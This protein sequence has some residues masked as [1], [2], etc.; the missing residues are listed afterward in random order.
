MNIL[1]LIALTFAAGIVGGLVLADAFDLDPR[2]Q[3]RRDRRAI[4][5]ARHE[6]KM[7]KIYVDN[8]GR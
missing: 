1:L 4:R 5:K 8:F 7:R 6:K 2:E 3:R